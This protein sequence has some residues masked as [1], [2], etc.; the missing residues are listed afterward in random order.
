[1][2]ST[3]FCSSSYHCLR[4]YCFQFNDWK[5]FW[6]IFQLHSCPPQLPEKFPVASFLLYVYH[7]LLL[8]CIDVPYGLPLPV[9]STFIVV[10]GLL[11]VELEATA[12][13]KCSVQGST[14]LYWW[15]FAMFEVILLEP[16]SSMQDFQVVLHYE[17]QFPSALS[18]SATDFL[19]TLWFFFSSTT[20]QTA[21]FLSEL[22]FR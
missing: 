4:H 15:D 5:Y 9:R 16:T 12:P 18:S 14:A 3:Q 19:Q 22:R 13:I 20:G 2:K 8:T 17:M 11:F 10:C 7:T 6:N 1:M 21:N